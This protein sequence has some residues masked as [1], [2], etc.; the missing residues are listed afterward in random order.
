LTIG[1]PHRVPSYRAIEGLSACRRKET[2]IDAP[3]T[4]TVSGFI[5]AGRFSVYRASHLH[6]EANHGWRNHVAVFD[7]HVRNYCGRAGFWV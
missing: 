4:H 2:I 5:G 7:G 1:A 6:E 3:M